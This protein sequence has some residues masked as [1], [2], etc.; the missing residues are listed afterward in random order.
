MK[1]FVLNSSFVS[2]E[3]MSS[4]CNYANVALDSQILLIHAMN[5][6]GKEDS[7]ASSALLNSSS[8]SSHYAAAWHQCSVYNGLLSSCIAQQS[9]F[10]D[11]CRRSSCHIHAIV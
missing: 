11:T 2:W 3:V 9:V 7:V 4:T 10:A 5:L 6:D 8:S 1:D